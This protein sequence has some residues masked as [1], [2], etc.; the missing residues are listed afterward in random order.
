MLT[1]KTKH[2]VRNAKIRYADDP[3]ICPVRAWIAYRT[4]L[5]TEQNSRWSRPDA[6]AFVSIDQWGHITGGMGPDSV[7]RAIKRI[8]GRAGVPIAWTGHS[9]RIGLASVGRTKGKDAVAIADQGGW[10]RHS[11]SILIY[12]QRDDGWDDNA[13]ASLT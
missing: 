8:S 6:P 5:A 10:A 3:E 1:G 13:S 12:M 9:V 2:S 4:G 11:R 7:T